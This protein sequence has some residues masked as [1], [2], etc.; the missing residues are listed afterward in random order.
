MAA[1]FEFHGQIGKVRVEERTHALSRQLKEGLRDMSHVH[2]VT[3]MP[4][5]LSAGLVC[6]D[7]DGLSPPA[8]VQRLREHRV[9]ATV[10]PYAVRDARLAP[11]IRN[12][13]REVD[14]TLEAIRKLA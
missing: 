14:R 9:I 8:A 4:D 3:P 12:V 11:S 1:A 7:V 13:P 6:F 5:S 10:T 2:L